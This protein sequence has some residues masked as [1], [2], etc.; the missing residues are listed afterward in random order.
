MA[1]QEKDA[2]VASA[3]ALTHLFS[4][5]VECFGLIHPGKAWNRQ[6]QLLLTRLGIQQAKLLVWGDQLG[7]CELGVHRD[8][9][10]DEPS[11]RSQI[12]AQLQDIID[13]PA[14]TDRITQFEKFGLKPP[15]RYTST[16]EPALDWNRLEAFRE[17]YMFM[18]QHDWQVKRGMSITTT[19][20]TV[21][22]NLRFENFLAVIT[23]SV[24]ALIALIGNE[25][26][27]ERAVRQDVRAL[28]YHPVFNRYRASKDMAKL[29]MIKESNPE[30]AAI[31]E[32][33]LENL[34]LAYQDDRAGSI[35]Q[36][37]NSLGWED[38]DDEKE[39][40]DNLTPPQSPKSRRS[41]MQGLFNWRPK[42]WR[43]DRSGS[44]SSS[45]DEKTQRSQSESGPASSVPPATP[46]LSPQRSQSVHTLPVTSNGQDS[47]KDFA[48]V[49]P[50]P[51]PLEHVPETLSDT[52]ATNDLK[53]ILT[54][55]SEGKD[56]DHVKS[57][58][59]RHDQWNSSIFGKV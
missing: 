57:M 36:R 39:S 14:H 12:E 24:S 20:W 58:I 21:V 53:Q 31:A 52:E 40:T 5:C 47:V 26:F 32:T 44:Q 16:S 18:R 6:Q 3:I 50:S 22:D 2:F 1:E 37:R 43:K 7:I 45:V 29:R 13:R 41:S 25:E 35:D 9:R 46:P 11:Y 49:P 34:R 27:V 42:T 10:L 8:A 4:T 23:S 54:A 28:G 17:K 33:A 55:S 48:F 38:K 30:Y 51:S 15:K 56:L 19:H 59:S